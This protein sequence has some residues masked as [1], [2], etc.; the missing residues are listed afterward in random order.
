VT[1]KQ[2]SIVK[3][4]VEAQIKINSEQNRENI[5]QTD[6]LKEENNKPDYRF[7]PDK[8][9]PVTVEKSSDVDSGVND[10][11]S[12][13]TAEE[14]DGGIDSDIGNNACMCKYGF[15]DTTLK[16]EDVQVYSSQSEVSTGST[17]RVNGISSL[18][19]STI[20]SSSTNPG[21]P[22]ES[23]ESQPSAQPSVVL[24]FVSEEDN[25][26]DEVVGNTNNLIGHDQNKNT[27][28]SGTTSVKSKTPLII[29][30]SLAIAVVA[31]SIYLEMVMIGAIA[32]ACISVIGVICYYYSGKADGHEQ[33]DEQVG[34][35]I[36]KGVTAQ[37]VNA[38]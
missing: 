16:D 33:N 13:H 22:I 35:D 28:K 2:V 25:S 23:H 18:F 37:Q 8:S 36:D 21:A 15:S 29:A 31:A 20:S 26:L 4:L 7:D 10:D 32:A 30:G 12:V 17:F 11:E 19:E 9:T 3:K 14:Y 38:R 6:Q 1:V 24:A 34:I 5:V 27:R